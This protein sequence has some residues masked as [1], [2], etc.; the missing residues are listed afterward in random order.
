MGIIKVPAGRVYLCSAINMCHVN[1]YIHKVFS[2]CYKLLLWENSLLSLHS[3]TLEIGNDLFR[4]RWFDG[5][6]LNQ[7]HFWALKPERTIGWGCILT[8]PGFHQYIPCSAHTVICR[9]LWLLILSRPIVANKCAHTV[10][11][12]QFFKFSQFTVYCLIKTN[13]TSADIVLL[14]ILQMVDRHHI[15]M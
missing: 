2:F 11:F 3:Y 8:S 15:Q 10:T 9:C 14:S 13:Q 5:E 6:A 7:S 4:D 12:T 1:T